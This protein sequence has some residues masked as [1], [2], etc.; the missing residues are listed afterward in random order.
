MEDSLAYPLTLIELSA[1]LP[2]LRK[3]AEENRWQNVKPENFR[4]H[5]D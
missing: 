1:F 5:R 2:L 3:E 4:I